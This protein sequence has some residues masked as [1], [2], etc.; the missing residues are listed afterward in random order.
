MIPT[1]P[2]QQM[3]IAKRPSWLAAIAVIGIPATTDTIASAR[4]PGS[5]LPEAGCL[6]GTVSRAAIRASSFSRN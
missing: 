6:V 1:R 4:P 5:L 2:P 3:K